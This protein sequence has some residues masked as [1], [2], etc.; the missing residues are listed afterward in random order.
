MNPKFKEEIKSGLANKR[1]RTTLDRVMT[2]LRQRRR[3][4]FPDQDA[5]EALRERGRLIRQKTLSKLPE[6]L[7]Q[8]EKKCTENGIRVHWAENAQEAN[9][10][11]LGIIQEKNAT[12]VVKGKS[13][14]SEEI[15][16]NTFLE[17]QDI[18]V[19]E[20]DLGEFIIQLAQEP[21][22]HIVVPSVHKS[23]QEIAGLFKDKLQKDEYTEDV[24]QLT[25]M[26]RQTMRQNFERAQ[27]GITGV[28]FAV[29]ETGTIC[30]VENEGNGRYCSS[31]PQ[32]HI[33]MMGIEKVV[34]NLTDVPPLLSLLTR[35]ATGQPITTYFNMISSPRKVDEKDGPEE[36]HLI[37]VD[38]G[39]T[40]IH[41]GDALSDVMRCIRCG[42]CMN[43]CPVYV[44]IGG[45]AYGTTIPG[46]IGE[47]LMP[48]LNGMKQDGHLCTASTLCGACSEVCPVQIPIPDLISKLRHKSVNADEESNVPESGSQRTMSESLAWK[49]WATAN[50]SPTLWRTQRNLMGKFG[51]QLPSGF[52]VMKEWTRYR[53][54]PKIAKSSLHDLV[55]KNG[56]DEK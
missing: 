12:Q 25:G 19:V 55:K 36:V 16:L 41:E 31:L 1:L 39:R 44:R 21:P 28:N 49:G 7:E 2:G 32:V 38:N 5:L 30:L 29:A 8:L 15:H 46:P 18:E 40:R 26:A 10:I 47:V 11:T 56:I 23:V 22:S 34:E 52:P 35:S 43:H 50:A 42:A 48:Q 17:Q 14:L 24:D 13:M 37:L 27:V 9:E 33:A 45:H 53:T 20:T 6:L 51:N 4:A 3:D 54:A